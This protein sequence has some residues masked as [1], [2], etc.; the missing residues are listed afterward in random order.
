MRI[1]DLPKAQ[2]L[3]SRRSALITHLAEWRVTLRT[4]PPNFAYFI[5][6]HSSNPNLHVMP[7]SGMNLAILEAIIKYYENALDW[8]EDEMLQLGLEGFR[9]D[10]GT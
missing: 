5:N 1:D 2:S 10:D 6:G 9:T 3:I 7:G 4:P 8:T